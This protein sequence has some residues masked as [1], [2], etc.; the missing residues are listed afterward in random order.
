MP[1]FVCEQCGA[2][3]PAP[4][5]PRRCLIC[6]DERQYVRWD[7]QSWL[8]PEA[9]AAR[10]RIACREDHGVL[11][12]VIEP[13]F[14]IGQRALLVE[15]AEGNVLWDMIGLLTPEAVAAVKA[16]GRVIA[17]A[18]SHPHYYTAMADWSAALG[19]V[20]V[21]IHADDHEWVTEPFPSLVPWS[22]E[23][24][25]LTDKLTL[26]RCGG[27]FPGATVLHRRD[28]A[29]DTLYSGDVLQVTADRR[30]VSFMWSYPN[31][32]PVNAAAVTRIAAA[33][34]PYGF[35]RIYGAFEGRV[36]ADGG[37]AAFERSVHR[38][39]RAIA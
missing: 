32:V 1:V 2:R 4:E 37:N 30:H 19:G 31:L 35:E 13:A 18:I 16:R 26:I 36:I 28:G 39:L 38:Y 23:W 11:G 12:L 25:A 15:S 8:S 3:Y 21:Y 34:L 20:P 33:L 6:E 7:G 5:A 14:A 22:G 9:L 27:H 29:G 17:I 24:R 10:H